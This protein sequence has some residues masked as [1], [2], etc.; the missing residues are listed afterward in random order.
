MMKPPRLHLRDLFWLVLV[1]AMAVAW[2]LERKRSNEAYLD[3]QLQWLSSIPPPYP[4][5]SVRI[6]Q[7]ESENEALRAELQTM[8]EQ[9]TPE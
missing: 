5:E 8:K 3:L 2:W 6:E 1:A 7:L 4:K 9:V